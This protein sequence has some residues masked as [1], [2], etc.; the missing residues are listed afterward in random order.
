MS[1]CGKLA[2]GGA[3]FALTASCLGLVSG[4]PCVVAVTE[5]CGVLNLLDLNN[6]GAAF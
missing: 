2:L 5:T 3:G 6:V 1:G 4:V